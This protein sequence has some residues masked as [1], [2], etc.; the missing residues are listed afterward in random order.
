MV[1]YARSQDQAPQILGHRCMPTPAEPH[2]RMRSDCTE[3]SDLIR[4]PLRKTG[5]A[6]AAIAPSLSSKGVLKINRV[7][8]PKLYISSLFQND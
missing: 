8:S 5:T 6:T 2:R 3:E 7:F 1:S 4:L